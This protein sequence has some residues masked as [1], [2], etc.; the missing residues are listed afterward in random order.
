LS[1]ELPRDVAPT[2]AKATICTGLLKPGRYT[3]Y[4]EC[5]E[6]TAQRAVVAE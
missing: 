6:A 2:D 4:G 5:N 1:R 3:S